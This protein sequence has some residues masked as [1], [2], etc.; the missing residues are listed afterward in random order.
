MKN[1][2]YRKNIC[3]IWHTI[4]KNIIRYMKKPKKNDLIYNEI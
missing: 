1:I 3:M 2:K 4:R